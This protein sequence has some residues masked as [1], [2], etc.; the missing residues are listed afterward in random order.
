MQNHD[1][2]HL[3]KTI[4]D[5]E[6]YIEI[7]N[8]N[9]NVLKQYLYTYLNSFNGL[10]EIHYFSKKNYMVSAEQLGFVKIPVLKVTTQLELV[11]AVRE[12]E[13]FFKSIDLLKKDFLSNILDYKH[14]IESINELRGDIELSQNGDIKVKKGMI[15][16]YSDLIW[17]LASSYLQAT[18]GGYEIFE[19]KENYL[20]L[21]EFIAAFNFIILLSGLPESVGDYFKFLLKEHIFLDKRNRRIQEYCIENDIL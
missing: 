19:K 18:K 11:D 5:D 6:K 20:V 7:D 10:D 4:D 14:V 9:P 21:F 2:H 8:I 15:H 16:A 17:P 12:S 13:E 1:S 3:Q